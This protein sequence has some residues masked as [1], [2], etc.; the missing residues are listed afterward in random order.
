MVAFIYNTA[1]EARIDSHGRVFYVDHINR[2]T[3][4]QRPGSSTTNTGSDLRFQQLDRRY[5]SVRRTI[6]R[7][8]NIDRDPSTSGTNPGRVEDC[9]TERQVERTER[10]DVQAFDISTIPAVQ[11]LCRSDFFTVL[12]TNLEALELY[13]RNTSLKYMIS[14]IRRDNSVFPRYEH[15]KDLVTIINFFADPTKD[16]P[17]RYESKLDKAGKVRL[18]H[19]II[20]YYFKVPCFVIN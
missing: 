11:F 2:I 18:I 3:T 9:E 15:N 14:K 7:P 8:D 20:F 16:L 1:W 5:Q 12:H 13:N 19:W 10:N 6:S 4:W 17:P